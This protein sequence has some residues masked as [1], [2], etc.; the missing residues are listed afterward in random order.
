MKHSGQI[1]HTYGDTR[2]FT[3]IINL[4]IDFAFCKIKVTAYY[5]GVIPQTL[6]FYIFLLINVNICD[7]FYLCRKKKLF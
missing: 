5:G 3:T 6:S 7:P 2:L 4:P 1:F